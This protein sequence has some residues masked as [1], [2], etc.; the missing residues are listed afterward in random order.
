[1]F[2]SLKLFLYPSKN[3]EHLGNPVKV[4]EYFKEKREMRKNDCSN[5]Y[6][7]NKSFYNIQEF[8]SNIPYTLALIITCKHF[9][10][11]Y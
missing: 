8:S 4:M 3:K 7:K 9:K 2:F 6:Y 11:W 1:M 5:A 10:L